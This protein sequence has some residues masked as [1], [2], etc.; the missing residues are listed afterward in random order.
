V[1]KPQ[2]SNQPNLAKGAVSLPFSSP[3]RP[4]SPWLGPVPSSQMKI[5][6]RED[7]NE[8]TTCIA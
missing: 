6:F 8:A 7:N 1:E 3:V 2:P 5:W 4:P